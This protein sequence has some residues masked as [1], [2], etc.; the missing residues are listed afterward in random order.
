MSARERTLPLGCAAGRAPLLLAA[1]ARGGGA[2]AAGTGAAWRGS[3]A[4]PHGLVSEF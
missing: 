4:T 1:L 2:A 3:T